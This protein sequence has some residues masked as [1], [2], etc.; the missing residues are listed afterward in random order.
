MT[1]TEQVLWDRIASFSIDE[2]DEA[3]TF[4]RRLARE[5]GWTTAYANRAIE[6]Y[7]RFMFLAVVAGHPVTPSDQVDQV[8]HLHL[9]YTQ[10]YWDRFCGQVLNKPI[11]HGPTKGGPEE[12]EKFDRWYQNTLESYT[13]F[14]DQEPPADIWP[15]ASIRFGEDLHFERVNTKRHWVVRKSLFRAAVIAISLAALVVA[16]SIW[17]AGPDR[18]L[19]LSRQTELR[20]QLGNFDWG[21]V[22]TAVAIVLSIVVAQWFWKWRGRC[23]GCG[24]RRIRALQKTG[25]TDGDKGEEWQCKACGHKEWKDRGLG[26]V[27]GGDGGGGCG[28]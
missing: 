13:R 27:I 25:A 7:K 22:G 17:L 1:D 24:L 3:L 14:F 4:P 6:E 28:G 16:S 15:D 8:W 21:F 19:G 5:N 18:A 11:H 20:A 23:P 9:T 2:G 26:T 12:A 10:S